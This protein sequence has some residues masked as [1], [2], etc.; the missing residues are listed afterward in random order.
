ME[1]AKL[2]YVA[3]ISLAI[4]FLFFLL[5]KWLRNLKDYRIKRAENLNVDQV[6]AFPVEDLS[7]QEQQKRREI[8]VDGVS[9][10]FTIIGRTVY[11]SLGL[12]WFIAL[13]LPFIGSLSSTYVSVVITIFTVV[14]G[15]AARPFI[16]NMFSGIVISFSHQLG[17][18]HTLVIDEQYGTVEDI[19]ITHTKIKTWESKRYIIPNSRMLTKE[20]INL[21]LTEQS[22]WATIT[23]NVSYDTDIN[24]VAQLAEK[25]ATDLAPPQAPEKPLFWVRKMEKDTIECGLTCWAESPSMAWMLKSDMS[26]GVATAFREHGISTNQSHVA[27]MPAGTPF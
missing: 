12:V 24:L 15:I 22:L 2:I 7:H 13:A 3:S 23:F 21:T 17:V 20:F 6:E 5:H 25:I 18:G 4:L 19:S 10:R 27:F 8:V 26:M 16:E 14:I 1:N 11:L 9:Q